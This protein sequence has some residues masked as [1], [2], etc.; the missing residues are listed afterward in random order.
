ML[1]YLGEPLECNFQLLRIMILIELTCRRTIKVT[2][3]NKATY[4]PFK[5][6]SQ[7]QIWSF[8]FNQADK[9]LDLDFVV[10]EWSNQDSNTEANAYHEDNARDTHTRHRHC[11]QTSKQGRALSNLQDNH[12]NRII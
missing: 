12:S 3:A 5:L 6:D 9:N 10:Y 7:L 2:I 8:K 1:V 4:L 11:I